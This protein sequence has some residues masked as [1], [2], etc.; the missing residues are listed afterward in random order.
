MILMTF[1]TGFISAGLAFVG[2]L[3]INK[4]VKFLLNPFAEESEGFKW[5]TLLLCCYFVKTFF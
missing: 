2:P 1:I 4:I 5:A 3:C